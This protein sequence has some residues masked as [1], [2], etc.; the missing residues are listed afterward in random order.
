MEAPIFATPASTTGMGNPIAPG[1][2]GEVGSGDV[3]MINKQ[4]DKLKKRKMKSLKD[5]LKNKK[6]DY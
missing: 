3:F 1:E 4:K 2:N 6:N 5:Y